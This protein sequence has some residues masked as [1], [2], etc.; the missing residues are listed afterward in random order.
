M[1]EFAQKQNLPLGDSAGHSAPGKV[2]TEANTHQNTSLQ[3]QLAT[4]SLRTLQSPE[5]NSDRAVSNEHT[6]EAASEGISGPA[7]TLPHLL[8]IQQSF[9][10]HDVS[11]LKAHTDEQAAAANHNLGALGY[12]I[13]GH[14]AFAGYPDLHTAAHE[15]AHAVQQRGGVQLQRGVGQTGDAYESQAN[16]VADL[17]AS[18][19][20]ATALLDQKA[21]GAR[22]QSEKP[23]SRGVQQSD[24]SV[25]MQ[26]AKNAPATKQTTGDPTSELLHKSLQQMLEKEELMEK[27]NGAIARELASAYREANKPQWLATPYGLQNVNPYYIEASYDEVYKAILYSMDIPNNKAKMA[28]SWIWKVKPAEPEGK[29]RSSTG[30]E[31]DDWVKKEGGD[32]IKDEIRDKLIRTAAIRST[33]SWSATEGIVVVTDIVL[34]ALS[35]VGYIALA[36]SILELL[37]LLQKSEKELSKAEQIVAKVKAWLDMPNAI[38]AGAK[39]FEDAAKQRQP[40]ADYYKQDN[41]TVNPKFIKPLH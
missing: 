7:E 22:G 39:A 11:G 38:A 14:V 32:Y 18:G 13:G 34:G 9:G 36:A 6:H 1:H 20:R 35:I 30:T 25:Q 41:T 40:P 26:S 3:L 19:K 37:I 2:K 5:H 8:A 12:T 17:V 31:V 4:A 21:G 23:T 16:A 29:Y 33:A 24:K 15:A 10:S 28:A 27:V